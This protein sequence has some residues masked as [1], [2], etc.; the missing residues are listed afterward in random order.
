[1]RGR[2][3]RRLALV[4]GGGY[5]LLPSGNEGADRNLTPLR[6]IAGGIEGPGHEGEVD[7]MR[8]LVFKVWRHQ[9]IITIRDAGDG[10]GTTVQITEPGGI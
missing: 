9:P 2:V 1:M 4:R 10:P 8:R 5:D 3:V 7:F 6:G